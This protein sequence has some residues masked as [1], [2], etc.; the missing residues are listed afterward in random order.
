MLILYILLLMLLLFIIII[1]IVD[2]DDDDDGLNYC[3]I[4]L[5]F[6]LSCNN[7]EVGFLATFASAPF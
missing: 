6:S 3:L 5:V 2:D 1:I 4:T 7:P